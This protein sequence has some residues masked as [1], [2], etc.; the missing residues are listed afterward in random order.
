MLSV[1]HYF[2]C[3]SFYCDVT[4]YAALVHDTVTAVMTMKGL[5][6]HSGLQLAVEVT[7]PLAL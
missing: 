2:F 3:L 5:S 6:F 1:F 7:R 4:R